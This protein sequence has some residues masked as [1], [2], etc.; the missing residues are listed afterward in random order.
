MNRRQ[1]SICVLQIYLDGIHHPII[2]DSIAALAGGRLK[3]LNI[4]LSETET[5]R[6]TVK[7]VN[8]P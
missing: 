4:S 6:R 5:F 7:S 8:K 2:R 1:S 3:K